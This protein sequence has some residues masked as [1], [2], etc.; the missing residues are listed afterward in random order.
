MNREPI[1]VNQFYH[2]CNR[3]NDRQPIFVDEAD[4]F[5][6]I[7]KLKALANLHTIDAPIYT[8]MPN[9][10]HLIAL[11]NGAAKDS[12]RMLKASRMKVTFYQGKSPAEGNLQLSKADVEGYLRL[13]NTIAEGNLR[14][15]API[16]LRSKLTGCITFIFNPNFLMP[17]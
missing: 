9:H 10:Y 8:L 5:A 7:E 4:Y 2:V 16:A 13:R 3:G 14:Q 6:F 1:E 17:Y 11:E 15:C 12:R